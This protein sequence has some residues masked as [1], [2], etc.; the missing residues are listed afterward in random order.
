MQQKFKKLAQTR[1]TLNL[2]LQIITVS[3]F[4]QKSAEIWRKHTWSPDPN[5]PIVSWKTSL[6]P[7]ALP[8][9]CG[10]LQPKNLGDCLG[11]GPIDIRALSNLASQAIWPTNTNMIK[12]YTDCF[13]Y[14]WLF[15]NLYQLRQLRLNPH[16]L[17][18][19]SDLLLWQ[20]PAKARWLQF[21]SPLPPIFQLA[22]RRLIESNIETYW[23]HIRKY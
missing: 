9:H 5:S 22:F 21:P 10:V 6:L 3:S 2:T 18:Q 7:R 17:P 16:T 4:H 20:C 13:I 14:I 12:I 1:S 8:V 23:N 11:L 15:I 19:P